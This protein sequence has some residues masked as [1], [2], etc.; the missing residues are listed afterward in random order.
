MEAG[1]GGWWG[2]AREVS[3]KALTTKKEWSVERRGKK[4]ERTVSDDCDISK[5]MG[6]GGKEVSVEGRRRGKK[7]A[8]THCRT[9]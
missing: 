4:E 2:R 1:K 6:K 5:A 8:R 7:R 9:L 3:G